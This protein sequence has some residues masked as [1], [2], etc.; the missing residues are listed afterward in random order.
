M[1]TAGSKRTSQERVRSVLQL[2][3]TAAGCLWVFHGCTCMFAMTINRG[4][5]RLLQALKCQW[6]T[7]ETRV[8]ASCAQELRWT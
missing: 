5:H 6:C 8:Y 7:M 4:R 2:V 1:R 3:M